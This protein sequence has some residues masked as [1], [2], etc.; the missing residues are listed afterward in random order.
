MI[1]EGLDKIPV[2]RGRRNA[3]K[4]KKFFHEGHKE[5]QKKNFKKPSVGAR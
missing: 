2:V 5:K 3:E 1:L 4:N